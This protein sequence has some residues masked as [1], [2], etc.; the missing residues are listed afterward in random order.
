MDEWDISHQQKIENNL[1][2]M[3]DVFLI[4]F[5]INSSLS[6]AVWRTVFIPPSVCV[7]SRMTGQGHPIVIHALITGWWSRLNEVFANAQVVRSV[8]RRYIFSGYLTCLL[9]QPHWISPDLAQPGQ[10][11]KWRLRECDF[12][13]TPEVRHTLLIEIVI[14]WLRGDKGNC[15]FIISNRL[16]G[17]SKGQIMTPYTHQPWP[18]C[19][20]LVALVGARGTRPPLRPSQAGL[21]TQAG[22]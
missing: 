22:M 4:L 17:L 14:N 16:R 15:T 8:W 6:L 20:Q 10:T 5:K 9:P 12:L 19:K 7:L 21:S 13:S 11:L 3:K 2:P 1:S 18:E